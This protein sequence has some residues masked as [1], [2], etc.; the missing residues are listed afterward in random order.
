[1]RQSVLESIPF[2]TK[3]GTSWFLRVIF[4]SLHGQSATEEAT[5]PIS[6][7][8]QIHAFV[9]PFQIHRVDLPTFNWFRLIDRRLIRRC[10]YFPAVSIVST[11]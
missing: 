2:R 4:Q 5:E 7:S 1:M 6:K 3:D 10:Q 8:I 9:G 11:L